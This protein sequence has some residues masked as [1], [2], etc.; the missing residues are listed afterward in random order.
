M[1]L[2]VTPV[3]DNSST[4]GMTA[5]SYIPDQLIAGNMKQVTDS[6]TIGGGGVYARGTMLGMIAATSVYVPCVKTA[7]DGSQ[8]PSAVLADGVDASGGPVIGPA[9]LMGEFNANRIIFD[10]SWAAAD[11]KHAARQESIFLKSAV[12]AADPT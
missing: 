2:T 12:S 7:N 8:I 6:V 9:Y 4:P 5:Y 3:G 1:T 11:L 10:P